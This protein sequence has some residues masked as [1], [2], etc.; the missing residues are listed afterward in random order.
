MKIEIEDYYLETLDKKSVSII[1]TSVS[2]LGSKESP[3]YVLFKNNS[4]AALL[5][6]NDSNRKK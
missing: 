2:Y 3:R 5:E 1:T 6:N 4:P